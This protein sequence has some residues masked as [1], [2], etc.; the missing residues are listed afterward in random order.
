[1]PEL[2]QP[3]VLVI[4]EAANPRL[5]SVALIGYSLTHA[6]LDVVDL[7]LATELRNKDSI[8]EAGFPPERLLPVDNRRMQGMAF[9]VAKFLRGGESLGWT[10][11]S[12]FYNVAYPVFE[13]KLW[14]QLEPRLKGGEFDLVHRVTPL[15][16]TTASPIAKRLKAIGVP[17]VIGPMNGGVPWPAGFDAIRRQEKEW[18]S[19]VRGLYKYTPGLQGTRDRASAL[20]LASG[21]TYREVVSTSE[22]HA[23]AIYLPE[24]AI[25]PDRFPLDS[26]Q[27]D[28]SKKL[29]LAFVGRL[30]PYKGAVT[31]LEAALPLLKSGCAQLD[32]I[33]DGAEMGRLRAMVAEHHVEEVVQLPGWIAHEQLHARLRQSDVFAFPSVREF[34]GG[35]VLEAMA[36]GLAPVIADYAGPTELLPDDCGWRVPFDSMDTLRAGFAQ[37]LEKL[38]NDPASV[39]AAGERAFKFARANFTWPAKAQ[40]IRQVYDWVLKRG[41]R[42]EFNF[43][44]KPEGEA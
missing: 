28:P 13:R 32:I 39:Q 19:Y 1:M 2:K 22:R 12:A 7:E 20:L 15:S 24:N 17:L 36:L 27:R 23:K 9:K 31:L 14:R 30:V 18:L 5:T 10:I 4:A 16:P 11:Y 34:G 26:V 41:P 3:R 37:Q 44:F 42:P 25:D 6:L 43:A 40:Q 35:V 33:G 29:R 8:L 38:A 21:H